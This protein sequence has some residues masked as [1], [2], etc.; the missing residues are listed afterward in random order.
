MAKAVEKDGAKQL[1]KTLDHLDALA[2]A[3][4]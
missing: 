2:S 3:S 1:D 4:A